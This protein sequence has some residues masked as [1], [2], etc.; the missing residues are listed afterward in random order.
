MVQQGT[1]VEFAMKVKV[2]IHQADDGYWAEVPALPGCFSEAETAEDMLAS[3]REALES[4]LIA[5]KDQ[6]MMVPWRSE[7]ISEPGG[8]VH[9]L[10][11]DQESLV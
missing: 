8:Q 9:W 10:E 3:I 7:E 5:Y 1:R 4:T 11:L 6:G 2:V